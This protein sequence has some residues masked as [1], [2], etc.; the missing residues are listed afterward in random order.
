MIFHSFVY[1][2]FCH[3][4]R[5]ANSAN[6]SNVLEMYRSFL[7][8]YEKPLSRLLESYRIERFSN[9]S[10]FIF[11]HNKQLGAEKDSGVSFRLR[12]NKMADMYEDEIKSALVSSSSNIFN[13]ILPTW[14]VM[15]PLRSKHI[16]YELDTAS[17]LSLDWSTN[18][19]PF[20][21]ALISTVH[22]QVRSILF[23]FSTSKLLIR[24]ETH[25]YCMLCVL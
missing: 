13:D 6:L 5:H 10:E 3:V 7:V 15:R 22:D 9:I 2:V 12:I 19:N 24:N 21:I 20:G 16:D 17:P 23:L 4:L 1:L 8:E 11:K 18:N 14:N 25:C